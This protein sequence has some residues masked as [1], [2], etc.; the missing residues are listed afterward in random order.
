MPQLENPKTD[1]FNY[2]ELT[3]DIPEHEMCPGFPASLES[4]YS[5]RRAYAF[6]QGKNVYCVTFEDICESN[7]PNV[8]AGIEQRLNLAKQASDPN[9]NDLP[10]AQRKHLRL[11]LAEC[12]DRRT[13]RENEFVTSLQGQVLF[14][15]NRKSP[16]SEEYIGERFW[17][18]EKQRKELVE[19]FEEQLV[20][21]TEDWAKHVHT[22]L[23]SRPQIP[24]LR[25]LYLLFA[26][27]LAGD[28]VIAEEDKKRR[29]LITV[30]SAQQ[31]VAN[32]LPKEDAFKKLCNS[33]PAVVASE[34][35]KQGGWDTGKDSKVLHEKI[36]LE[37]KH[38]IER[39]YVDG[40]KSLTKRELRRLREDTISRLKFVGQDDEVKR[41]AI[42]E[43]I[44]PLVQTLFPDSTVEPGNVTA[45][46]LTE[47]FSQ[48][49]NHNDVGKI[50]LSSE[51][52]SAIVS[53]TQ[54]WR[55]HFWHI[56]YRGKA[57][58]VTFGGKDGLKFR[59]A[60]G[61]PKSLGTGKF[62]PE[63]DFRK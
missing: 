15:L 21:L 52:L 31:I 63:I 4:L 7:L 30:M 23:P 50:P 24:L 13:R 17:L 46:S 1:L 25:S 61:T 48:N 53:L 51:A 19:A 49:A 14:V 32:E 9:V 33:L 43:D 58:N 57:A 60:G 35:N 59:T 56:R 55:K 20:G 26:I 27:F 41:R 5:G 8:V 54:V 42:K 29:M 2:L 12:R 11:F 47:L 44:F 38:I 39:A 45:E 34:I 16:N 6:G 10:T 22:E 37:I 62:W 40:F 36:D 18:S 28:T 3:E